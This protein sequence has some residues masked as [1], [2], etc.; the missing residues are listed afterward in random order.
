MKKVAIIGCGWVG[1]ALAQHMVSQ[2]L[3]VIGTGRTPQRL[4]EINATGAEAQL[5]EL[6]SETNDIPTWLNGCDAVIIA[7][8]PQFKSGN[9]DYPKR[10]KQA[11]MLAQ[12]AQVN[13]LVLLSSTGVYQGLDGTVNEEADIDISQVKTALL[14]EAEQSVLSLQGTVL[15]LAGL[16]G[17]K[18]HP[19]RFM[20]GKENLADAETPTNLVH[21]ADV[22]S[23]ITFVLE[24]GSPSSIYNVVSSTH[25][26]RKT[27][28]QLACQSQQAP[29]PQFGS[30]QSPQR[31][32]VSNAK[33]ISLGWQPM[34]PDL[35][36]WLSE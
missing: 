34:H 9:T 1:Q 10:V 23:A 31:R 18:R 25:P 17:P 12:Q 8:T 21:Q 29:V 16:I 26:T 30:A 2:G 5:F 33:L 7:I 13:Q 3:Q 11:A 4:E 28:Y 35:L 14:A 24:E 6:P 22:V 27:F 20:Q 32:V 36:A 19:S 15:R